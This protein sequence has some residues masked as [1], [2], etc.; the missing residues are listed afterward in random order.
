M[1]FQTKNFSG[2]SHETYHDEGYKEGDVIGCGI[3]KQDKFTIF[4]TKNGTFLGNAFTNI[5]ND[6]RTNFPVFHQNKFLIL[7]IF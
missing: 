4:F 2:G 5:S 1:F 6:K 7:Y 3:Y